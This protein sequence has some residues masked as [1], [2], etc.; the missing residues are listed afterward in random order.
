MSADP[1]RCTDV[2]APVVDV[3]GSTAAE[4]ESAADV[5]LPDLASPR[6]GRDTSALDELLET[7]EIGLRLAPDEAQRV[8]DRLDRSFGLDIELERHARLAVIEP[9]ERHD[10]GVPGALGRGPGDA[11]V[12]GLLGDLG[13]PGLLLSR[14]PGCP[15]ERGVVQLFHPLDALHE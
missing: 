9:V 13:R 12:G 5:V 1:P 3:V 2:T 4:G 14:D 8:A 15:A 10:A 6:A 7:L 11:P